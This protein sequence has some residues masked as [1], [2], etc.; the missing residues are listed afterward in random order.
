MPENKRATSPCETDLAGNRRKHTARE[1]LTSKP[2]VEAI[3]EVKWVLSSPAPGIQI[4]PHYK[5]LLG[6]FYDR[7]ADVYP[8]HEQL[9]T[10]T[11]PDE[12]VGQKVM[13]R[14]RVAPADWPLIQIGPG[15]LTVNDTDKYLWP[16]FRDRCVAVVGKLFEAYPEPRG[17]NMESLL[18]RYIDAIEFDFNS[19]NVFELLRNKFKVG[20]KLPDS[21]FVDTGIARRPR[22]FNWQ[23]SFQCDVP[24]GVVNLGF[25]TGLRSGRPALLWET[26]VQSTGEHLPR[27]PQEF[28]EWLDSAHDITDDWFFKLIEGELERRFRG[29]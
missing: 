26:M 11:M 12:I 13:H 1:P 5:I 24:K 23:S 20:I 4:D 16:D 19:E 3:L 28:N 15:I 7:V 14:F 6:R 2:L 8:E 9:P 10:A 21:L 17:L 25:A 22:H 18:L 27:M 29:E